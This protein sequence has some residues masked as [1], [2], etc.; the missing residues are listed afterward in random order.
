VI[1]AFKPVPKPISKTAT[2]LSSNNERPFFIK[3]CFASCI[4]PCLE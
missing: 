3:T 1:K 2:G 4:A